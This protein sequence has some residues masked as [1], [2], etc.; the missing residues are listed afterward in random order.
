AIRNDR[1]MSGRVPYLGGIH[2]ADIP[3]KADIA[4]D[5]QRF[6]G[7]EGQGAEGEAGFER[8]HE[9]VNGWI[10]RNHGKAVAVGRIEDD[11][12]IGCQNIRVGADHEEIGGQFYRGKTAA[13]DADS[14]GA[15]EDLDGAAHGR[16]ELEDF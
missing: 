15:W 11:A 6:A 16:L 9:L 1:L 3:A 7:G 2:H 14:A 13:G 8:I 12:V 4:L 5:V 10:E